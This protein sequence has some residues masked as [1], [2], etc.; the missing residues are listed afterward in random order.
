MNEFIP[1]SIIQAEE[2]ERLNT[3]RLPVPQQLTVLFVIL[4]IIFA[5]ATTTVLS[6][7]LSDPKTPVEN[8]AVT[9]NHAAGVETTDADSA[10]F[11]EINILGKA[12]YVFDVI[13]KRALYAKNETESL[14]LASVTK[15][16]TIL[17]AHELLAENAQVNIDEAA[18]HQYGDSG[19]IEEES[20]K[21]QTLSDLVILS[22][23]ND[24][25]YAL[26]ASA[27]NALTPG[28]GASEFVSAMN[29]RAKELGLT[30]TSFKNPTGL[31]ISISEG[32]AYGSAKDMAL[33]M[34]YIITKEPD[35]LHFSTE[36]AARLYSED[37]DY[38]DAEN[39]NYYIDELPGLI[40]SKTGYTDLAGGNLVVAVNVGLNRP[41][42]IAVLGS[43]SHARFTDVLTLL[44]EAE[45]YIATESIPK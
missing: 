28:G 29:I 38:H 33:L 6:R 32:G 8:A 4:G 21:R 13:N 7:V 24:G 45:R 14:P 15:L 2:N 10:P 19:L 30:D 26:A 31:D 42:I 11:T 43:T 25:A 18:L 44:K 37:G 1:E 41:L 34:N 16:M 12:A 36:N 5:G 35:L 23:S 40:G 27:G 17:V 9:V 22:S 20:F 39:T 3:Y